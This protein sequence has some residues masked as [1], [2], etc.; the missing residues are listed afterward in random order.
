MVHEGIEDPA[1]RTSNGTCF[2]F[3]EVT[4]KGKHKS[5]QGAKLH[6]G[7][8]KPPTGVLKL[9]VDGAIFK[10]QHR[11]RVG[12]IFRDAAGDVI[13]A[14]SK[15]EYVVNDLAK[16]E[17]LAMLSGLQLCLPLGIEELILE[18]D[19]L[20]MATQLED[21]EESWFLGNIIMETKQLMARFRY[22]TIQHVGQVGNVAAHNLATHAWHVVDIVTWWDS[23]PGWTSLM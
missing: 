13:L 18:S 6:V 14:A 7:W 9:N 21:E 20:M 2:L 22:C 19:S 10:D 8:E 16:L 5:E 12:I 1:T 3:V 23:C 17:L 11:A 4:S 15:K